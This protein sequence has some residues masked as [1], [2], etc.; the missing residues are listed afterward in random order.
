M[1]MVA[2]ATY[3]GANCLRIYM[4]RWSLA[5]EVGPACSGLLLDH[6]VLGEELGDFGSAR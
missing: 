5:A 4:G 2:V 3:E 1:T 6:V